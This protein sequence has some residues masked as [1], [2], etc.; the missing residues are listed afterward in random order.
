[1]GEEQGNFLLTR[2]ETSYTFLFMVIHPSILALLGEIAVFREK[3][4][5]TESYFGR[6]AVSDGNFIGDLR[7]GRQPSL[8][9]IDRVREFM[10]SG[11]VSAERE[12]A[13]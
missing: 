8:K 1:M 2:Q 13:A 6:A 3:A 9:L 10:Q 4:G 7:A 11:P 5:M 12:T